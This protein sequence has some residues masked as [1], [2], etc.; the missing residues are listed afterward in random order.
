[1]PTLVPNTITRIT[2][3]LCS[4]SPT[5]GRTGR[6]SEEEGGRHE[7]DGGEVQEVPREGQE[8]EWI[9]VIYIYIYGI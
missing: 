2:Q 8:C 9:N 3:Y 1:M 7:A 5:G 6:R 4:L